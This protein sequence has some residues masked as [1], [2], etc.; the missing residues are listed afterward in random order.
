VLCAVAVAVVGWQAFSSDTTARPDRYQPTPNETVETNR[1]ASGS[2]LDDGL[3]WIVTD[4]LVDL[5]YLADVHASSRLQYD[6]CQ[7]GFADIATDPS[8][9]RN[10]FYFC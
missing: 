9:S 6:E 4:P 10:P 1:E 2:E 3:E 7:Q 8:S 5:G